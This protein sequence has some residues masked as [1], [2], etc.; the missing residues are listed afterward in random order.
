MAVEIGYY[1]SILPIVPRRQGSYSLLLA[2]LY[3]D[4]KKLILVEALMQIGKAYPVWRLLTE[5][6]RRGYYNVY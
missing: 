2:C 3:H 6:L 4:L 1:L 5:P